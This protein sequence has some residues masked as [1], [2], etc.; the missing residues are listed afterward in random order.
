MLRV[1]QEDFNLC[2]DDVV[3]AFP[4]CE[5]IK[6]WRVKNIGP[7]AWPSDTVLVSVTEGLCVEVPDLTYKLEPGEFMDITARIYIPLNATAEDNDFMKLY[8]VRLYTPSHGCFGEPM[9]ATCFLSSNNPMCE[10]SPEYIEGVIPAD[11]DPRVRRAYDQAMSEKSIDM[12]N[13]GKG[14]YQVNMNLLREC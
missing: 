4:G 11:N 14:S 9:I 8:I 13:E 3:A 2:N 12:R 7:C 1:D 6:T 5:I 10:L